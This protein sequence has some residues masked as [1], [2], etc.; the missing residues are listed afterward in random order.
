MEQQ[1]VDGQGQHRKKQVLGLGVATNTLLG[2]KQKR[3]IKG[4][5]RMGLKEVLCE[6]ESGRLILP[7]L[8]GKSHLWQIES[9]NV[10]ER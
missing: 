7:L 8:G 1:A 5:K 9:I 2:V 10:G 4:Q 3:R 6:P